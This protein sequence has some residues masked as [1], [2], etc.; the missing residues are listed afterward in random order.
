MPTAALRLG[1]STEPQTSR[2]DRRSRQERGYDVQWE[3]LRA[4]FVIQPGN[5]L[6]RHCEARGLVTVV[7][8]VDH[9]IPIDRGGA[10]LNPAN[11]QPLCRSCHRSKTLADKAR[12]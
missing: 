3:K 2:S 10:R 9:I 11:L 6:C 12:A 8:E 4:W 5:Q 1:S 7:A